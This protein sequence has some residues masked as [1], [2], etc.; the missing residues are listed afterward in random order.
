MEPGRSGVHGFLS[1]TEF[2]SS[3]GYMRLFQNQKVPTSKLHNDET[4]T[5]RT[6]PFVTVMAM[7]LSN[8]QHH[9]L[10][11]FYLTQPPRC[12]VERFFLP[13]D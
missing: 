9:R 7:T 2:E 3:L 6:T 13:N 4:G 12:Q 10:T 5:P 1:Y 8:S 11:L